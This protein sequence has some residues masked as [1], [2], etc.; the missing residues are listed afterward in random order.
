[1][2]YRR[3][4]IRIAKKR[5]NI[6]LEIG[7]DERHSTECLLFSYFDFTNVFIQ[8]ACN[9][10]IVMVRLTMYSNRKLCYNENKKYYADWSSVDIG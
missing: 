3:L 5:I 4:L 7:N 8:F 2:N 6:S 9:F 1:M 10:I